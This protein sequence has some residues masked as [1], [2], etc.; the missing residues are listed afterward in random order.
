MVSLA[1]AGSCHNF[2]KTTNAPFAFARA[3]VRE[4]PVLASSLF[5][6]KADFLIGLFSSELSQVFPLSSTL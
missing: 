3:R 5:G 6:V 4:L 2:I 1:I